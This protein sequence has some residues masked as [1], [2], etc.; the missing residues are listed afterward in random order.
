M[1]PKS[2]CGDCKWWVAHPAHVTLGIGDCH[3]MPD[4]IQTSRSHW[5]SKYQQSEDKSIRMEPTNLPIKL[6]IRVKVKPTV[7]GES[8]LRNSIPSGCA[9]PVPCVDGFYGFMLCPISASLTVG[10]NE[11]LWSLLAHRQ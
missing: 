4:S 8:V 9:H 1:D 5:C 2:T 6:N 7:H 10:S 3:F 11:Y